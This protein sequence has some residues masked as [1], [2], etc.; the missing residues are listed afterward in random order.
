MNLQ[1]DVATIR[2]LRQLDLVE[3]SA[4]V[5]WA[6]AQRTRDDKTT[7]VVNLAELSDAR[8]EDVDAHLAALA[9]EIGLEPLTERIAGLVAAEQVARELTHGT[10]TPI[11]AARRIWRIA[12]LAPSAEPWLRVFVG[13]AS[14]W[15]DDPGNRASYEEEIRSEALHLAGWAE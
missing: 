10:V 1:Q 9:D 4:V 6:R 8:G 5:G 3:P 13:L 12:R 2:A 14:E 15:E 7:G 11:E